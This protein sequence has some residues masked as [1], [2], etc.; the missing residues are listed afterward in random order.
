M[1]ITSFWK[2]KLKLLKPGLILLHP[3]LKIT[4]F[5]YNT[6]FAMNITSFFAMH[7]ACSTTNTPSASFFL[8]V[9][10]HGM[11]NKK[12]KFIND[13]RHVLSIINQ[14]IIGIRHVLSIY[15]KTSSLAQGMCLVLKNVIIGIRQKLILKWSHHW[16]TRSD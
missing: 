5:C 6:L 1:N 8:Q 2:A 14:N 4:S 13:I 3:P 16:Q 15:K 12:L 9:L 11:T 10:D 7:T